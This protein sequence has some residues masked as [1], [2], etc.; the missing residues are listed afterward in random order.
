MKKVYSRRQIL[1]QIAAVSVSMGEWRSS[2]HVSDE[3][4]QQ[5]CIFGRRAGA[6]NARMVDLWTGRC[7]NVDAFQ[8]SEAIGLV[9][10]WDDILLKR[11]A[12]RSIGKI[13]SAMFEYFSIGHERDGCHIS[14]HLG[15]VSHVP[16]SLDRIFDPKEVS[17]CY[18]NGI[19]VIDVGACGVTKLHWGDLIPHLKQVYQTII[20]VDVS[21]PELREFDPEFYCKPHFSSETSWQ[22]LTSCDYSIIVPGDSLSGEAELRHE[23]LSALLTAHINRMALAISTGELIDQ[24]LGET[25]GERAIIFRKV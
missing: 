19:A 12:E 14:V 2:P 23:E 25:L 8:V 6:T 5:A 11:D 3:G 1:S 17:G 15:D 9:A 18:R 4:L 13:R 10:V 21:W 22:N 7:G 16:S 20:G 24:A